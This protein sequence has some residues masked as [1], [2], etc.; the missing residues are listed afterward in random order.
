[1]IH[2]T[3]VCDKKWKVNVC[4][5]TEYLKLD[6]NVKI[7]RQKNFLQKLSNNNQLMTDSLIEFMN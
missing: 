5:I 2:K 6:T 3:L 4:K 1:M 7:K